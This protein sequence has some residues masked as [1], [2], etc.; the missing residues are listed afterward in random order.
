MK[1]I[2]IRELRNW[3]GKGWEELVE[4]D[5]VLTANGKPMALLVRVEGDPEETLQVLRRTRAALALSRLRQQAA[6]SGAARLRER[7]IESEVCAGRKVRR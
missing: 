6:A 2:T 4:Q 5:L 3:P 1:F 7:V